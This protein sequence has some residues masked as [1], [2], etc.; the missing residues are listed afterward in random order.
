MVNRRSAN[1]GEEIPGLSGLL[2]R[3]WQISRENHGSILSAHIPGMFVVNGRRGRFRAV[4]ITGTRCDLACEHC[5][6]YL[7][8][9]MPHTETPEGLVRF[10]L[11]ASDRNDHGILVTG[12]CDSEGKLPWPIFLPAI[13]KLKDKT[14][15]K[16]TVHAGQ[17]DLETARELKDAGVDQALV[18]VIGDDATARDVYHLHDGTKTILRTLDALAAVDLEIVPHMLFGLHYGM[19]R[20]EATALDMLNNYP[21]NQYVVV[22]IMPAKETPMANVQPPSPERVALFLAKARFELP[23]VRASLGCARPRGLYRRE[24]DVLA[25]RAGINA[26]ALPSDRSIREAEERGLTIHYR[27]SCCSLAGYPLS[28][29]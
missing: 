24:L 7:L 1:R 4:S 16:I 8:K 20:G 10:G 6:G 25:V 12:G 15:L 22:V 23:K 5:K 2:D 3:A 28:T 18:D 19:E 14:S 26:L 11:E 29:G 21:L 17:V 9:T 13:R 27:E